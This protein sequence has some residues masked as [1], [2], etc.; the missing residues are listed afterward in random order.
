[1]SV[2]DIYLAN[3]ESYAT[4]ASVAP[5]GEP[6]SRHLAVITCMDARIDV[7]AMLGLKLGEAH[8]IRNA[9]GAASDDA[10]RSLVVS[11]RELLTREVMLIHHTKCGMLGL[12][13]DS[14]KRDIEAE[15]GVRPPWAA[16]GF[17][18]LEEDVR[19]SV[20]RVRLNPFVPHKE[21][22]RGFIY[23]VDTRRLH[24]VECRGPA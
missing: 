17:E 24:E 20:A 9:G 13:D 7:Y 15:T 19:Q 18:R 5:S 23:D 3:N 14:F 21:S 22:V 4:S 2:T 16:E 8:V 6:P 10:I 11:Q 1:M 12:S